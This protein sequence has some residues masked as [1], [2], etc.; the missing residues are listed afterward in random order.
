MQLI[1]HHLLLLRLLLIVVGV[2]DTTL[3]LVRMIEEDLLVR[4]WLV[5][6]LE[7]EVCDGSL[8][9]HKNTISGS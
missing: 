1:H 4:H 7:A 2:D 9:I 6:V 3:L 5:F 8:S